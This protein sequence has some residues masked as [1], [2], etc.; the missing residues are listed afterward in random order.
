MPGLTKN[1]T[2][3]K[4]ITQSSEIVAFGSTHHFGDL[5]GARG[6]GS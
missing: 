4:P 6:T 2:K 1:S 5:K 3:K